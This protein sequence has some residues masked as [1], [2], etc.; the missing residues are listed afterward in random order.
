[1]NTL[2]I[3]D[4]CCLFC[5]PPCPSRI[6]AKL[7]FL[8]PE[9]TYTLVASN[10]ST[11]PTDV[12]GTQ[13]YPQQQSST[14]DATTKYTINFTDRAEWQHSN[15]EMSLLEPYYVTTSR[16]NRIACL[17]IKCVSNPKYYILFSH[18]NAVDLGQMSS[19]FIVLGK[20]LNCNIL[21]YDYSG[22]GVSQ[23]KASE[24]NMYCDI[25]AAYQS[26]KQRYHLHESQIILYGQS[27]GTVPVV[28]LAS[29]HG[30]CCSA[31]ILHSPLTSG[32]RVAFPDTKRTWCCDAFSSIDKIH[33]I[34]SIVLIIHGTEDDVIDVSHG[35]A[36][37]NKLQNSIEP[38]WVEGGGHNDI[39][40]HGQYV[41]R[42]LKLIDEEVP[43]LLNQQQVSA[44]KPHQQTAQI[45]LASTLIIPT[46]VTPS[47]TNT[48][49]HSPSTTT[50][51]TNS[52]TI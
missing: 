46:T 47:T 5:C 32:M 8:P 35:F 7:A 26:L 4:L 13:H 45:Q 48:N 44:S 36:L 40:A 19:F 24:K 33:R 16:N 9:P 14:S 6:A 50:T 43:Q 39:E 42:L 23:G 30:D 12:N 38:L 21:S 2:S 34:R 51:N 1:M 15:T 37:Y 31:V 52:N 18:G 41:E 29:R 11:S 17:Y 25:E 22:Y 3:R 49:H 10:L 20:R 27:I 28:D